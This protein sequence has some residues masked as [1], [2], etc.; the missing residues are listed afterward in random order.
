MEVVACVGLSHD[1]SP[2]AQK[3]NP[4]PGATDFVTTPEKK[5]WALPA[6]PARYPQQSVPSTSP[7][8]GAQSASHT[9]RDRALLKFPLMDETSPEGPVASFDKPPQS[10]NI[11][12][13]E[14]KGFFGDQRLGDA[15]IDLTDLSDTKPFTKFVGLSLD[16]TNYT[17]W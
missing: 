15:V 4:R 1:S 17:Y 10:L 9:W 7:V 16:N 14:R 11:S 13:F 2:E 8:V 12:I 3:L 5:L 6:S